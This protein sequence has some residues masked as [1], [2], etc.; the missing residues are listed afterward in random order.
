MIKAQIV[1]NDSIL[2]KYNIEAITGFIKNIIAD[3]GETYKRSTIS[4]LRVLF[5][6][7][8]PSGIAWNYNGTLNHRVRPILK[9]FS[10][11]KK[12]DPFPPWPRDLNR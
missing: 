7:I 1:K 9:C 4:Q 11:Y 6:S 2:D 8:F 5:G 3:L 10:P 12:R